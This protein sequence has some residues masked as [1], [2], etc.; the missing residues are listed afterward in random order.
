MRWLLLFLVACDSQNDGADGGDAECAMLSM[1][2]QDLA[3]MAAE[4]TQDAGGCGATVPGPCCPITV[5]DPGSQPSI[6]L[7][8]AVN[9]FVQSCG[10]ITCVGSPSPC[11]DAATHQ[12]ASTG[13]CAQR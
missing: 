2:W 4:C 9:R 7:K 8:S 13:E 1:Q 10:P 11:P 6:A 12:C 5:S 3:Y